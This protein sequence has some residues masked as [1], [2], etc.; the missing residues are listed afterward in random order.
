MPSQAGSTFS[1]LLSFN[2]TGGPLLTTG[3][4]YWLV[5][6]GTANG[7]NLVSNSNVFTSSL[8]EVYGS[9]SSPTYSG[10]GH[11]ALVAQL[12]VNPVPLPTSAWLLGTGILGFAGLVRRRPNV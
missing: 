9:A 8:G 3:T 2:V 1:P 6:L 10:S 7:S 12:S 4:N 5:V 11:Q